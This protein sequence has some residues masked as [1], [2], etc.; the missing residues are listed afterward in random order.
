MGWYKS[1]RRAGALLL[2][3]HGVELVKTPH[4]QIVARGRDQAETHLQAD[5]M[6]IEYVQ[7]GDEGNIPISQYPRVLSTRA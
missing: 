6:V 3:G 1:N 5:E 7:S 2:T 4:L